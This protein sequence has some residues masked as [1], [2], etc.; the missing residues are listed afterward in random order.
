MSLKDA[1]YMLDPARWAKDCFGLELDPWQCQ[2]LKAPSKQSIW[3]IHRQAGKSSIASLKA[4]HRAI[5]Y[6]GSLTLMISK[7][8]RQSGELYRKFLGYFDQL[9]AAPKMTEDKALSC[10]LANGSRVIA[11]PGIEDTVRCFSAV[12]LIIEDEAS[13]VPDELYA[14]IRPM[15][16]VS[17]GEIVLMSTPNGRQGHFFKTWTEGGNEWLKIMVKA[18]QCLRISKEFLE[19]E[20]LN[21]SDS[22]YKQEYFCEFVEIEG[23]IFS[24]E[25]FD[26]LANPEIKAIKFR[27]F[28]NGKL[29]V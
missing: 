12:N 22:M 27:A 17:Q 25:L 6:P 5:Y 28:E 18:D 23:S 26:S 15:L 13:R 2:A 1:A 3:N 4:L 21:M 24:S 29:V 7:S 16:A 20:R 14:A 9:E 8:E 11:L 10:T 19:N